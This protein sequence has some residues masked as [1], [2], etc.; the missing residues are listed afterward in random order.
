MRIG[1]LTFH[2]ATNYGAVLQCFALQT[3]LEQLN[4][5]VKV[6]NYKPRTYDET[7]YDFVRYRKFFHLS[8][9]IQTLKKEKSLSLF[10]ANNL[11]QTHRVYSYNEIPSISNEF[12]VII[13]GSDQVMNPYF[14]RFGEGKGFTPTYFLAFPF[15]GNK[16]A[17]AVSFGCVEY[18]ERERSIVAKYIK[19]FKMI[20]VRESTGIDIVKS[21]GVENAMLVP[22]PTL[23]MDSQFYHNLVD[24]NSNFVNQPYVYS[25]FIRNIS[26]RKEQLN[27]AMGN[28]NVVWNNDDGN[29]SLH[30]WLAKIKHAEFVVTDS[31]HC[32]VM[33]LKLHK[34]FVII[35]D[36]EGK[37]GMNDRFYTLL[38]Y[39]KLESLLLHK[40]QL[41]DLVRVR[42]LK[43]DW[44]SIDK[45]LF[46]YRQSGVDF[47]NKVVS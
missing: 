36:L 29:Y 8:S 45:Q 31:F 44:N 19:N 43:Y 40:K 18:P 22:D 26:E 27:H 2:W 32:M 20:S 39:L 4:V 38:G 5:E 6:I 37:V 1:I 11:H 16:V 34:P 17:Y 21:M 46:E 41:F 13:V 9:Y 42:S 25:F 35:T 30:A 24:L 47:L 15:A 14:L 3:Y 33:C 28:E 23:L 10:R 12:D 7:F